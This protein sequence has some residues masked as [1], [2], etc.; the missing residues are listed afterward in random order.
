MVV[1]ALRFHA[2]LVEASPMT[3]LLL[4]GRHVVNTRFQESELFRLLQVP[5]ASLPILG[6]P[7][8]DGPI[9]MLV[10][11]I[12]S[13]N[14]ANS[15]YNPVPLEV[16]AVGVDRFARRLKEALGVRF[17]IVPVPHFGPTGRFA[18]FVLKELEEATE[19]DL[20]MTPQNTIVFSATPP[21]IAQFQSLGFS[22]LLGELAA[23]PA[24]T[25]GKPQFVAPTPT[26]VLQRA[27]AAGEKWPTDPAVRDCLHPSTHSV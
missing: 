3:M 9:D 19:G 1:E 10:F 12:T 15:R 23:Y 2:R 18:S 4:P 16:R 22:I 25:G 8:A 17:R 11:A 6:N 5:L 24:A 7:P 21:V 14:Q 27:V 26:E 13:S 20:R